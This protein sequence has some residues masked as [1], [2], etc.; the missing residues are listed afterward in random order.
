MMCMHK[1][2]NTAENCE[3][4]HFHIEFPADGSVKSRSSMLSETG[5]YHCNPTTRRKAEELKGS[6]LRFVNK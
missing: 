4:Y 1:T 3:D 5:A 2:V 6:I